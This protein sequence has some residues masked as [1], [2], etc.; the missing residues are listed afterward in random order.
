MDFARLNFTLRN[1]DDVMSAPN[2]QMLS[3]RV[4]NTC[5]S[6]IWLAWGPGLEKLQSTNNSHFMSPRHRSSQPNKQTDER[7]H[8]RVSLEMQ[9]IQ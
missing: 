1:P 2:K 5:D 7:D 9:E 4:M 8:L 3:D 6:A